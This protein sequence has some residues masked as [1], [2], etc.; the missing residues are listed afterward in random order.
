M[1]F[2][3]GGNTR[4]GE[5]VALGAV[6]GLLGAL[7]MNLL[8]RAIEAAMQGDGADPLALGAGPGG[9]GAQPFQSQTTPDDDA[10][11]RAGE[12]AYV[13]VTGD[14]PDRDEKLWLGSAAHYGF[15][16]TAGVAYG[17]MRDRFPA[18]ATGRGLLYGAIVWIVADEVVTPALGLSKDARQLSLIQLAAALAAH[19][20]YGAAVEAP[21]SLRTHRQRRSPSFV[22]PTRRRE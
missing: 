22:E 2:V 14:A 17:L 20:V 21:F 1:S 10:A 15:G 13:A 9:R 19:L 4:I 6:G 16:V 11:A 18:A 7:A 12:A 8:V 5:N 3:R